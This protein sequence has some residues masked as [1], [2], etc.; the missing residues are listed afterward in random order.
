MKRFIKHSLFGLAICGAVFLTAC[1]QIQT[2]CGI[3]TESGTA[4]MLL[5]VKEVNVH[6]LYTKNVQP[7]QGRIRSR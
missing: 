7:S 4:L 3:R 5:Q 6:D 2:Q 1:G